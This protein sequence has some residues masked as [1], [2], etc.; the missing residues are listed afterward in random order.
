MRA[1]IA[2]RTVPILMQ[3]FSDSFRDSSLA[4]EYALGHLSVALVP[5]CNYD[6]G[7]RELS[8]LYGSGLCPTHQIFGQVDLSHSRRTYTL[9][10]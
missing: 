8:Q 1:V 4:L 2:R 10:W 5:H 6:K 9:G 7:C 3:T